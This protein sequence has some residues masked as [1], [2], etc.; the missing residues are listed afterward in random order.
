MAARRSYISV[1]MVVD[2]LE[3]WAP[4]NIFA[5]SGPKDWRHSLSQVIFHE[6]I[7][8]WQY[9]GHS[10]LIN[11]LEEDWSRLKHFECTGEILPPGKLETLCF[12]RTKGTGF[13]TQDML[14]AHA[15]FWDVQAPGRHLE[16]DAPNRDIGENLAQAQCDRLTAR[17]KIWNHYDQAGKALGI[18]A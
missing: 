16:L 5:L 11:L 7:H 1:S 14:E 15:R 6:T 17:G 4:P 9:I 3:Q 18:P 10:H 2:V 8:Y 12:Q 13:S